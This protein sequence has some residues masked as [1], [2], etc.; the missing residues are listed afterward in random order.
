MTTVALEHSREDS[1]TIICASMERMQS[2]DA[3]TDEG[4]RIVG[5]QEASLTGGNGARLTVDIPEMQES[6]NKT[7]VEVNAE[8]QV[9]MDMA[10]N[11]EDI[12]SEF[13]DIANDLREENV[14]D[15]LD[16]LAQDISPQESK[17]V[18]NSSEFG[19]DQSTMGVRFIITFIVMMAFTVLFGLM[20]TAA[21][22]P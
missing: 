22:M 9:S 21:M 15:L 7:V 20:M 11:P 12:K 18:A 16:D 17:E 14:D 2:I 6:E 8:K 3:Y 4:Q 10:T 1:K 5:K 13:L 19:D